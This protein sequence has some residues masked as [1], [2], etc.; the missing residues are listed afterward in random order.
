MDRRMT[1][2]FYEDE[3]DAIAAMIANSGKTV[4]QCA[5]EIYPVM[6][7]ASAYA[8]LKAQLNPDGDE[9]LRFAQVLHLMKFCE[10]YDPLYYACDETMHARPDRKAPEDEE[11]KLVAAITSAASVMERAMKQLDYLQNK[12]KPVAV[13]AA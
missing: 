10:A 7:P 6:K 5:H 1:R 2:L 12:V 11:V 13:R 8:K 4:Q 3:H 9:H